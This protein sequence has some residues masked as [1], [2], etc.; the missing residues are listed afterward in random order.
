MNIPPSIS[1]NK[2]LT[3]EYPTFEAKNWYVKQKMSTFKNRIVVITRSA[4]SCI[5]ALVH[6]Q[7]SE[8]IRDI[9]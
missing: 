8:K 4:K 2:H 9:V 3:N 5:A 1:F 7:F 6:I